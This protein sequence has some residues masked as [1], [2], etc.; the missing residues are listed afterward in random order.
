MPDEHY[1]NPKLAS[2]YD[3]DS[4]WSIE[5]D[6]YV[7]FAGPTTDHRVLDI[8]CGTG[9]ISRRLA[10]NGHHVVGVD[11]AKAMLETARRSPGGDKVRW[12]CATAQAMDLGQRFDR[13]MMS[14]NAFQVLLNDDD[15]H[16]AL[17]AMRRHLAPDGQ[18]AFE[19]RNP[20]LDWAK[21][22]DYQMTLNTHQGTVHERRTFLSRDGDFLK[23][24]LEYDFDDGQRLTSQSLLRFWSRQDV[25]THLRQAGLK[26]AAVYGDWSGG[27]I[28]PNTSEEMI[29][30]AKIA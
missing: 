29:F 8:G 24:R 13:I 5:R 7:R 2:L 15:L 28:E 17:A 4:G 20:R 18:L 14:G 16:A 23:F 3:L 25:E 12:V 30:I 11:P 22:W 10:Q 6:F 1:I 9:L 27:S 26:A 19:T 21:R